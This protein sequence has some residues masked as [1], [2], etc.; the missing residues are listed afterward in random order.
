MMERIIHGM[1][2]NEYTE[3]ERN[4]MLG[5]TD[6]DELSTDLVIDTQDLPP[7]DGKGVDIEKA[8][9]KFFS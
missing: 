7:S 5:L 9:E 1:Q 3:T 8:K 4:K 2:T 6:E